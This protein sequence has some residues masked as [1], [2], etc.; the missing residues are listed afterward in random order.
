MDRSVQHGD[1]Q[2]SQRLQSV[3]TQ[4]TTNLHSTAAELSNDVKALQ[5][6]VSNDLAKK[7]AE[8][9]ALVD[10]IEREKK[11]SEMLDAID[12]QQVVRDEYAVAVD[13]L[14][15]E[16]ASLSLEESVLQRQLQAMKGKVSSHE[17][18][19]K[20][21]LNELQQSVLEH[22]ELFAIQESLNIWSVHEATSSHLKLGAQFEDVLFDVDV[23]VD[24]VFDHGEGNS[25]TSYR[26]AESFS[27]DV[28]SQVKLR[29]TGRNL[30][31]S[32]E[33]D[34]VYLVQQKLLDSVQL[35][36]FAVKKR[37]RA[38][39]RSWSTENN[40]SLQEMVGQLERLLSRSFQFLRELR[41][42]SK[43]FP[44]TYSMDDSMLWIEFITFPLAAAN[45]VD[46]SSSIGAKFAVG[47]R[48]TNGFPF[49]DLDAVIHVNYG[50]VCHAYAVGAMFSWY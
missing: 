46:A 7:E 34:V 8:F 23:T 27:T 14:E 21:A 43:H 15:N 17:V 39:R 10:L 12:E 30:Y 48:V 26:L 35:S 41:A 50:E 18:T 40:A 29:Q 13:A 6:Q 36:P 3:E 45:S 42:L 28:T 16:C 49:T 22:E 4:L 32:A 38:S 19:S 1:F 33:H 2:R 25:P 11:M 37:T 24:V 5:E 9:A 31:I 20:A 44:L 47:F